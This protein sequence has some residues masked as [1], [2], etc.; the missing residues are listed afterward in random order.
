[1]DMTPHTPGKQRSPHPGV[2]E[3]PGTRPMHGD[4]AEVTI[5]TTSMTLTGS[6]TSQG[7]LRD[8]RGFVEL[9]L[10]DADPQ[11]RRDLESAQRYWYRLYGDGVLLYYSPVLTLHEVRRTKEGALVVTGAP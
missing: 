6:I 10:P 5:G 11:Q 1:M 4:T 8:G 9:T 7:V 2:G 3:F